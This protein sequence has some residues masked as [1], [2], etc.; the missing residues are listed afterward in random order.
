VAGKFGSSAGEVIADALVR[1][2]AEGTSRIGEEH[3]F[4]ALL[5][6]PDSG[7]LLGRLGD[8]EE[9]EA[10]RAEVREARRRSGLVAGEEQALAGDHLTA[11][12]AFPPDI[13]RFVR[14]SHTASAS[15]QPWPPIRI[16]ARS[17]ERGHGTELARGRRASAPPFGMIEI[18]PNGGAPSPCGL[19]VTPGVAGVMSGLARRVRLRRRRAVTGRSSG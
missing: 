1:A 4:A 5:A 9:A 3:L 2:R 19:S 7:P 17:A 11:N 6:S 16:T 14:V 8:P 15:A 12:D 10:V 18:F 13:S